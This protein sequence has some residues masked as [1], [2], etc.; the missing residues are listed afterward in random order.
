M[1]YF[2]DY[3]TQSIKKYKREMDKS[4]YRFH[5]KDDLKI[6]KNYRGI[7]TLTAKVYKALLLDHIEPEIKKILKKNQDSIQRNQSIT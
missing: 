7:I 2:F 5:K 6:I 4:P 3:T 1:K